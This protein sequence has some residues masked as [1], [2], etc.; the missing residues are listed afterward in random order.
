LVGGT[1]VD[2][3]LFDAALMTFKSAVVFKIGALLLSLNVVDEEAVDPE[4]DAICD[5]YGRGKCWLPN[6]EDTQFD[7]DPPLD[8]EALWGL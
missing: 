6:T 8:T 4:D 1:T 2:F 7:A 3:S 5:P